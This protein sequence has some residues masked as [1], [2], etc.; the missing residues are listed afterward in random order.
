MK[1]QLSTVLS[2]LSGV[3]GMR[4]L[5]AIVAGERD[6]VRWAEFRDPNVKASQETIA[7]SLEGTWRPEQLAILKRQLGDGDHVQQQMAACD[8]D[9]QAMMKDL[10]DAEMP[11]EPPPATAS[12]PQRHARAP[13]QEEEQALEKCA[14]LRPER[15]TEAGGRCGP[16]AHR[17]HPGEHD[18]DRH[19]GG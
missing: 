12:H 5:R 6:G 1:V 17:R 2:D 10:P 4:I 14:A 18:S 3:T 15:G 19:H 9:L 11:S 8:V 13:A 7:K 16:D